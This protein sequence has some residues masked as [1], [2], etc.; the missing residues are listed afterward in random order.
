[1]RKSLYLIAAM[2]LPLAACA[3]N[4]YG[5]GYGADPVSQI[6][7]SIGTLGGGYG[8]YGQSGYGYGY[9]GGLS[10]AAASACAS[11]AAR[12]GPV[13]VTSVRQSSYDRVKVYGY[14][15]RGYRTDNWDC[16]FRSDGRITD[17][18]I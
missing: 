18:D 5:T 2:A 1:M 7:G 11:V 13:Q 9:G 17:F 16:T 3:T 10:Q 6:L 15:Q 14:A 4:P 12:Y 8:G